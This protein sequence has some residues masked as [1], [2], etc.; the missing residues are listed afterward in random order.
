MDGHG[1]ELQQKK[2]KQN[3][4]SKKTKRGKG[5]LI[6]AKNKTI[7]FSLLGSNSN[8]LKAKVDSLKNNIKIFNRPSCI[9]LQETKL[10][11]SGLID[12]PGY[13][14]FQL[15]R[16][17]RLGG[18]LLTA[19][20]VVLEP[21]L[22]NAGDDDAEILV[23]QIKVGHLDIRVFNAY[24]PQE[25]EAS[26]SVKFWLCLEK[27]I[28]KAKQQNCCV[29][30]EMDANAKIETNFQKLSE[31]GKYM[32][33]LC[34]RQNL[35]IL[36]KSSACKGVI[37][38]HRI[39]KNKE[40]KS[41]LDYILV[42]DILANYFTSMLIDEE[43]IFTLTKFVSTRGIIK[44]TKS[45]H[46]ILYCNFDLSYRKEPQAMLRKEVFN[47]KSLECQELFK[48]ETENTSKFTDIFHSEEP[49]E[50]KTLK[51]QRCLKQ[52]IRKCFRKVR[53]NKKEKNTEISKQLEE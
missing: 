31:N 26:S 13:Q 18:G 42:C 19:V 6:K 30:L 35:E 48:N 50:Q 15:N 5:K 23:V 9:L 17:G 14:I 10:F 41:T 47:L 32:S 28:M 21:V 4:K 16:S 38:R 3:L 27:E 40:E 20:D 8:G 39:T 22:V 29:L 25:D 7:Q 53:V 49:F 1:Q 12:L 43:R 52:S 37:T 33:N 24:G 46:N 51:F 45:D 36:N 2:L 11:R 44:Q 34:S